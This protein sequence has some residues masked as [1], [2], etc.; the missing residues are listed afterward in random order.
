MDE[1]ALAALVDGQITDARQFATSDLVTGRDKALEYVRGEITDLIPEK[2]KSSVTSRDLSDHLN[3]IMPGLLR[4]FLS[5]DKVA[6]YEPNKQEMG[7]D[8]TGK[9]VD[10]SAAR[11]DQAT[12]YLNHVFLNECSGYRVLQNAIYDGLLLSNGIIKHWWDDKP[13]Y[14]TESFSGLTD[15]KYTYIV[16]HEDVEEVLEHTAYGGTAEPAIP[17]PAIGGGYSGL[18][19]ET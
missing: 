8:E 19:A 16:N 13:D 9:V 12:D 2:D 6:I 4:V 18:P 5:T 14:K 3:W 10:L 11:A 7:P 15:D 1:D 17:L